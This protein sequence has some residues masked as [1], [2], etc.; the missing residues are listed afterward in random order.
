MVDKELHASVLRTPRSFKVGFLLI[1][2]FTL[3][4]LATAIEPL[5]VANSVSGETLYEWRTIA[6]DAEPVASSDGVEVVPD[7]TVAD[8]DRYDVVIVVA[9]TMVTESFSSRETDW[10]RRQA[11]RDT[12]LGAVCTG[13]YVLG[14]AGLL[15]G[16]DCSA[17]WECLPSLQE[18]F[19]EINTNNR[20]F[21]FDRDRVTCTGGDIPL[22]MMMH[23]V[24]L[25]HGEQ[26]TSAISDML[27][28][29]RIRE[30]HEPQRLMM[31]RQTSVNQPKLAEAV[32]LMQAN[33][34]EP[35]ETTRIAELI[36]L[37]R[38]QLERLFLGHLGLSPSRFYLR[39]RL[40]KSQLMLRQTRLPVVEIAMICGFISATHF[41]RCYRKYMGISPRQE[42]APKTSPHDTSS[43]KQ[44]D[45]SVGGD[46]H[47]E[48]HH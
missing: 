6:V 23:L 29:E 34:E 24:K 27:V 16:Y 36:G 39:L 11:R 18:D 12:T 47:R 44:V 38:R 41:S 14:Q 2:R 13:A 32:Q 3:V 5:R 1:D 35:L 8:D 28:C 33:L 17:H 48:A 4:A 20:L 45:A 43:C 30:S 46:A 22:H 37:S 15:D 21:T 7:A 31:E 9:G 26:L 25:H 40:E 19:P 42:R 10:L